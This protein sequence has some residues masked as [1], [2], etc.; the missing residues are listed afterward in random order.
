MG[1]KPSTMNQDS[2]SINEIN[3]DYMLGEIVDFIATQYILT[4]DFEN[5]KNLYKKEY[6]DNL[7]VITNDI[8]QAYFNNLEISN[9]N[10]RI[11]N[12]SQVDP[13]MDYED[14]ENIVYFNK[15]N[16]NKLNLVDPEKKYQICINISKFYVK[17]AH[18]F[19]AIVST[20]N[21]I[22]TYTDDDG[23]VL[24]ASIKDKEKIPE[25]EEIKV[26]KLNISD[27]RIDALQRKYIFHGEDNISINP[28]ICNINNRLNGESK[29]L[30]EEP[31]IEELY[32][33]YLDAGFDY[34]TGT[35]T[36]MSPEAQKQYN[37][38]LERFYKAF[39]GSDTMPNNITKFR[40]IKL[41]NY[42]SKDSCEKLMLEQT[43]SGNIKSDELFKAYADNLNQMIKNS[44]NNQT[45]L[46]AVL[47]K[48]FVYV[49]DLNGGKIIRINPELTEDILNKL[50]ELTRELLVDYYITVEEDY[51]TGVKI[52]EAIVEKQIFNTA[53][54]QIKYM[55]KESE[56]LMDEDI[57]IDEQ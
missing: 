50:I 37:E 52:Y 54:N 41:T 31:G 5:L 49:D 45:K 11:K 44:K 24:R 48:I 47:N 17:I 40:D 14:Y 30:D 28:K 35:F 8:I 25:D 27:R 33:L 21:P 9:L 16:I 43:V 51:T 12:G 22:Y 20:I 2:T 18:L 15:D 1:N 6:C 29:T 26:F 57:D 38:D 4:L 7:V 34:E 46:L 42:N 3:N 36:E 23:M 39:T 19:S 56:R 13:L 32:E 55:E 10:N 53:L